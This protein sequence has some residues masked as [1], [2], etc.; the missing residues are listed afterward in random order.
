VRNTVSVTIRRRLR[1]VSCVASHSAVARHRWLLVPR[2][3]SSATLGTIV[4][5]SIS[6]RAREGI[7][8]LA[9]VEAGALPAVSSECMPPSCVA[10]YRAARAAQK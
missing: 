7:D 8:H 3:R 4:W 5:V 6:K 1:D 9:A 10:V 2:S